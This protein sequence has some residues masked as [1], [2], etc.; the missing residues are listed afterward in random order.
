[1]Y[2]TKFS[3]VVSPTF[4]KISR[5]EDMLLFVY[6]MICFCICLTEYSDEQDS[7]LTATHAM[8]GTRDLQGFTL[9][10]IE[11]YS[12][13]FTWCMW[14]LGFH[15]IWCWGK[16]ITEVLLL[17]IRL[18]FILFTKRKDKLVL[19]RWSKNKLILLL[20][21]SQ[22][23]LAWGTHNYLVIFLTIPFFYNK[24]KWNF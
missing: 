2:V 3:Y 1:M 8:F 4:E 19:I 23:S 24:N 13:L 14:V 22:Y 16:S 6:C 18:H 15:D 11:K 5:N 21:I 20:K 10:L 9:V 7:P 17:R 12:E